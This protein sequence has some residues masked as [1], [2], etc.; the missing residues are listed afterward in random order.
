MTFF[1]DTA[2]DTLVYP[3]LSPLVGQYLIGARTAGGYTVIPRT[4]KNCQTLR[5]Y[6]H[7]VPPIITDDVYDWPIEPGR[8]PL[9]HQKIYAN[10]FALHPR[11]MNLGDPGTMKTL[12]TLWAVDFIMQQYPKGTCRA[13]VVAPLTVLETVWASAIFKN[14]LSRRSFEILVG[15]AEKRRALLAKKADISIVNHDGVGI[16]A[17]T[18]RRM[19]LDGLSRDIAERED[20]KIVVIDEASAYRDST[21]KRSRIARMAIGNRPYLSML[22]GTPL[23]NA[24]TDGY[25]LAKML[26]NCFGES[27]T[28]FQAKTMRKVS[29]FKWV[30]LADGYERARRVLTPAVR[31]AL[32]DIWD[33][34]LIH[35]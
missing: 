27:F 30:P 15:P 11:S 13:L 4:L 31:F 3:Q 35:I 23:P 25:G 29:Q 7:P 12:S 9:A 14:F 1:H 26:N 18:R 34:S 10:F 16:G 19:E 6:H 28:S 8:K 20:I 22:T 5:Y 32:E 21:T 2:T 24:P 17:H 33:L